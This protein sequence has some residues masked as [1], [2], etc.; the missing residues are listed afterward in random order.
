MPAS[1]GRGILRAH[2]LDV[3]AQSIYITSAEGHSGKSTVALGVLDTLSRA[4]PRVGVFRPIARSTDR[5]RLRARDAARPRRRRPATTTTCIGVTYDDVRARP[6]CRARD[7]RRALQGRRGPVRRGRHRRQRLHRRR[8]PRRARL[9]RPHRREPRRARAA[10]ARRPR[11]RRARRSPS[12]SVVAAAHARRD[13]PDRRRSRSP[14]SRHGRAELLAV[15]ANRAD[16]DA[17]DEIVAAIRRVDR[18]A[19]RRATA[20][21]TRRAGVGASPRTAS[22]SRRRSAASCAPSTASC[23]SRATPTCSTREALGVV[24]AG[25][26]MVNVLPRLIEGARRRHPGRPHRGAARRRCSRNASGT[27]PSIVGIVLN[28]GVPAARAD[29]PAH[30]RPRVERCRSSRPTSAPTR[31]RVRDHEHPRPPRRRL[32]AHATTP[33]SRCS[34]STSTPTRCSTRS[35][36]RRATVV[37]PLMFEYE[38]HRAG[39]RATASTSCCPRATTTASC[40]PRRRCSRAASPTSRSSAR[41]SR[42]AR[43]RSSS[44]S[45]SRRPRCSRP[46]DPVHVDTFAEE[47]ARLRAHKGVTLEQARRHRAPTS[48]TSAR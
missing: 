22:S 33:R 37:T 23:S 4:T 16:P 1:P 5:A 40:A 30:R 27:F 32:A 19:P 41:R 42:C 48:R 15:V 13:R 8:Q 34:S 21:P 18:R 36:S 2:R 35:A 10:R 14:S 17:L 47:Y 38:L 29:R 28:G 44:A 20:S 39:P 46:L 26:S 9:Q 43:A 24:V 3:V 6:G 12:S 11:R 45:T 31:P 7:D 25:M